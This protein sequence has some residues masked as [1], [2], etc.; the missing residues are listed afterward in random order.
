MG[1]RAPSALRENPPVS[2]IPALQDGSS[3][4]TGWFEEARDLLNHRI[5]SLVHSDYWASVTMRIR[6]VKSARASTAVEFSMACQ[7]RCF[8]SNPLTD[9]P[10]Q[11][12]F[13]RHKMALSQADLQ[14]HSWDSRSGGGVWLALVLDSDVRREPLQEYTHIA[15][16]VRTDNLRGLIERLTDAG[17]RCWQRSH[18]AITSGRKLRD[19][20]RLGDSWHLAAAGGGRLVQLLEP[21]GLGDLV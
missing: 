5:S 2:V 9:H 7:L 8:A 19:L 4:G 10:M 15:F 13:I 18:P 12:W 14:T 17:V 3:Y 20:F 21:K 1:S 11:T 6:F 16:T